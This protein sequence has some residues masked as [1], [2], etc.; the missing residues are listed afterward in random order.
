MLL[1]TDLELWQPKKTRTHPIN[2]TVS[3][4]TEAYVVHVKDTEPWNVRA[5][6]AMTV[7]VQPVEEAVGE[8]KRLNALFAKTVFANTVMVLA[9]GIA[10]VAVEKVNVA[11]VPVPD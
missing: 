1:T 8:A 9:I 4:A 3:I 2:T 5:L 10:L 6:I 7:N 11:V